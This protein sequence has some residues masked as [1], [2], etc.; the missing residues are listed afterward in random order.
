MRSKYIYAIRNNSVKEF[1]YIWVTCQSK[2]Q[3][4]SEVQSQV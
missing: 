2:V 4:S 3:V 1:L